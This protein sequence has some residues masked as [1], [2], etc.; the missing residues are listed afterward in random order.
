[1]QRA[2][3]TAL[4]GQFGGVVAMQPSTGQ[5]LAVA[6]IG[7]DG[8]QPPGSTFKMVTVTGVLHAGSPTRTP[9]SPTRPTRRSTASS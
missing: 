8:L 1:M 2:A 7:L 4:G 5:I 9:S 6:G 3:V